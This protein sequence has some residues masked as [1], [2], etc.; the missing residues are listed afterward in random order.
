MRTAATATAVMASEIRAVLESF[1]TYYHL[2]L[3][4]RSMSFNH[5]LFFSIQFLFVGYQSIRAEASVLQ[6]PTGN[7]QHDIVNGGLLCNSLLLCLSNQYNSI[8]NCQYD[9]RF[10]GLRT[11]GSGGTFGGGG[12]S[13][14]GGGC[15]GGGGNP[16]KRA[17]LF[18]FLFFLDGD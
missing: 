11:P 12:G 6:C 8:A 15:G 9:K 17:L 13:S 1:M 10:D 5:S 7:L 16:L 18:H 3:F 14:G 4:C 2:M